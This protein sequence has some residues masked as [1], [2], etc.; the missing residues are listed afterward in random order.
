M[1]LTQIPTEHII[2]KYSV[3]VLM[4]IYGESISD[5]HSSSKDIYAVNTFDIGQFSR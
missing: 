4:I 1:S 2:V 3:Y 5:R